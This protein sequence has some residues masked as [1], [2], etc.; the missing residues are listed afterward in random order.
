MKK[1]FFAFAL[2][3]AFIIC[4]LSHAQAD[5][6]IPA[7]KPA[8]V[9]HMLKIAQVPLEVVENSPDAPFPS[10]IYIPELAGS[11]VTIGFPAA[12]IQR[13][14]PFYLEI[15]GAAAT[16]MVGAHGG[17]KIIDGDSRVTASGIFSVIQCLIS[18][19]LTTM[20]AIFYAL[21]TFDI[22]GMITAFFDGIRW[23]I[24]CLLEIFL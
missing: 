14:A 10:S 18:T 13:Q 4:C 6:L 22:L 12:G 9:Q 24:N 2:Q 21:F 19:I 5:T 3:L 23:I 15:D 20:Q 7:V 16:V 8:L 11:S 1:I 17:L